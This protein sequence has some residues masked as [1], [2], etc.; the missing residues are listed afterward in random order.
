MSREYIMFSFEWSNKYQ[1]YEYAFN[2]TTGQ[3]ATDHGYLDGNEEDFRF[4]IGINGLTR[5]S[6][7]EWDA[8]G[9][10]IFEDDLD[11][12]GK[13][14][15]SHAAFNI[16]NLLR[17]QPENGEAIFIYEWSGG[18]TESNSNGPAEGW[19]ETSYIG[20]LGQVSIHKAGSVEKL[21]ETW[22][23]KLSDIPKEEK[24]KIN[25]MEEKFPG[26]FSKMFG[27]RRKK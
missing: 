24:I 3:I 5:M 16:N 19:T 9:N 2:C 11:E 25:P 14:L 23:P 6:D 18:M 26:L 8:I 13:V 10:D 17:K 4:V 15:A 7:M 20:E 1:A 21:V 27:R 22:S 12:I